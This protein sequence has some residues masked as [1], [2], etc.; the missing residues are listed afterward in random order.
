MDSVHI[1]LNADVGEGIETEEDYMPFLSSCSIAC[2]GHYGD[3]ESM[4]KSMMLAKHF[5]VRI[6]AHPSYPDKENFGRKV[7]EIDFS[8]LEQSIVDQLEAFKSV[9]EEENMELNHIK[10]HGALY[11]KAAEDAVTAHVFIDACNRVFEDYLLYVPFNSVMESVALERG[12]H[13]MNEAFGDR[14]Y[15]ASG[16]LVKRSKSGAV[17]Q[18]PLDILMQIENIALHHQVKTKGGKTI[19]MQG[20]TFC[21]HGDNPN[22]KDVLHYLRTA[23]EQNEQIRV[24]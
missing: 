16:L 13:F 21:I 19:E 20:E 17:L 22:A 10:A 18:N 9:M 3:H 23:W 24:V 15:N 8:A 14:A 5:G 11:N 6:G 2:G 1:D 7:M 12:V 4:R